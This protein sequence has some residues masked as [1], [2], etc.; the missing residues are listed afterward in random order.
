[1]QSQLQI[2]VVAYDLMLGIMHCEL[3]RRAFAFDLMEP[4]RPKADMALLS[5]LRSDAL[6]LRGLH[7]R[8]EREP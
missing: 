2:K 1:M 6:H 3:A 8:M 7:S 4:E 5:F